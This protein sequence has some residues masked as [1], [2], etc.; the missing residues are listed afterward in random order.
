MRALEL[1]GAAR[2]ALVTREAG[3]D[4][5]LAA[6]VLALLAGMDEGQTLVVSPRGV[7]SG[8][9]DAGP[10]LS[11]EAASAEGVRSYH[12]LQ[13]LGAGGMGVVYLA[14]RSDG[15]VVQKVALKLLNAGAEG[16]PELRERFTRER[17]LL[18]RL[19]HPGI[20]RLLDGGVLADGR[21]FLAMEYVEGERIDLHAARLALEARLELFIKVCEA[22]SEAHRRLVIHRDIKPANILVD[23]RGQPRLL[24]F[25]IAGLLDEESARVAETREGPYALTLAYASPEQV[26][27]QPLTTA[28]DVY[29]LGA[30][31]YQLVC[32]QPPFANVDTPAGLYHAIVRT[33]VPPPSRRLRS[34]E[35]AA[36]GWRD[37]RV[38]ADID[39]IVLKALRK[40]PAQRYASVA[41]LAEDLQRY[42]G[43]RPVSAR[44]GERWYRVRRYLRRNAW[45]LAGAAVVSASV[46]G[47][48]LASVLAL[49]EARQQQ[50]LAEQRG[51]E[52]QRLA[53]FQQSMLES[54]DIDAMGHALTETQQRQVFELLDRHAPDLPLQVR[55]QQAFAQVGAPSIARDALEQHVVSHALARLDRDFAEAPSLA[56]DMRQSLARV[57]LAIG[58][59]PRAAE[60]LRRVLQAR[61]ASLPAH[62][63]RVVS[64]RVDLGQALY[65]QGEADAAAGVFAQALAAVQALPELSPLRRAAEAGAARVQAARGDLQPALERQRALRDAWMAALPADDE[66]LLQLRGDHVH[67]LGKLG[68]RDEAGEEMAAL[69][70]L[71]RARFGPESNRTLSAMIVLAELEFSRNDFERSAA[72]AREVAQVRERR[73]GAE[74]PDTL[75]A[76]GTAATSLVRLADSPE[77]F[78]EA[79]GLLDRLLAV[80]GRILG[81]GHPTTR[82]FVVDRIRLL[83][84]QDRDAEAIALQRSLLADCLRVL[85]PEHPETL[86]AQ[87]ALASLLSY[88]PDRLDEARGLARKSLEVQRRQ[89]GP[90]HP[91]VT[92]TLDLVGRIE[93]NAG[94]W[95]ASRDA[96]AQALEIRARTRG[97]LDAHTIESAS[98]LYVALF[99]LHDEAGMGDIRGRFLDPVIAL[100]PAAI[101]AS[102]RSVR[103]DAV[104]ALEGRWD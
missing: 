35:P 47:G 59:Y 75:K 20:A 10:D 28:T 94:H 21:P 70:P 60:E 76:W 13:R 55:L 66:S 98:R 37:T 90:E 17:A 69:L 2:E 85:G 102:M 24:D 42:L 33:D 50:A 62:D 104:M 11:G 49:R 26:A 3:G 80:Q 46:L 1:R 64:T 9:G 45:P 71:Y 93:R 100:D 97:M 103:E 95:Q 41:A 23:A 18:A 29:S 36:P 79:E 40:E 92:A 83:S 52:L 63:A 96:H 38:P 72:L 82:Q 39:A 16:S 53:D 22:V 15:G 84:K 86:F 61:E 87:G 78:A 4:G 14:E 65:L 48:L 51:R 31:L 73:L 32:G 101:N 57:L 43:H 74:H 34:E 88:G 44:E 5:A 89:L 81:I 77:S 68:R 67:T 91:I 12:L 19:D 99:N 56:A 7:L 58:H 8:P 30:V 27:C 54:V 25:G 6:E